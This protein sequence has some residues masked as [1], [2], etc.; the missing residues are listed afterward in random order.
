MNR[1]L[2]ALF[3]L[4]CAP[5]LWIDFT[6]NGYP[7]HS[8]SSMGVFGLIY[9]AGWMASIVR[10]YNLQATGNRAGGKAVLIAQLVFLCIAQVWNIL[11]ILQVDQTTPLFFY[12]DKFWPLSNL[13]MIVTGIATIV[14]GRLRGWRKYMPLAVGL[15]FPISMV[16]ILS[17]GQTTTSTII[18]GLYSTVT[19][20]LLGW[21]VFT[22][23]HDKRQEAHETGP[24]QLA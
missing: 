24:V 19:W 9:M 4:L 16:A 17:I 18:S 3:T 8:P 1:Y 20:S 13:F 5:F 6:V 21:S 15:W 14:A 22:A 11:V 2:A 23:G 10:L 12:T 7:Q